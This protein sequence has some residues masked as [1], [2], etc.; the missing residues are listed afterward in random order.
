MF[1]QPITHNL[2]IIFMNKLLYIVILC[3]CA[4]S[5]KAQLS[6]KVPSETPRLV[7]G[8]VIDHFKSD[9]IHRYSQLLS[10]G[11][12]KRL[13]SAGTYCK[14][15]RYPYEYSQSGI[16]HASIYTGTNPSFHGVI[17]QTWYNRLLNKEES[18]V[19]DAN[20][21]LLIDRTG[22][23][24]KSAKN[25]LASTLGDQ[26]KL[27]SIYSKVL[28]V[29]I[30]DKAAIF[31]A[32]HAADAAYWYD[33]LSGQFI[34]STYYLDNLPNWV[35]QFNDKKFTDF[36]L[37]RS[38]TPYD[39]GVKNNISDRLKAKLNLNT[40]FSYDLRKM[41]KTQG[42]KSLTGTP[43]AN[44]LVKDF[45]ISCIVNQNMGKDD[46]VDLLSINFSFLN[47]KHKQYS[48]F[49][50]EMLDTF[51][52]LDKDIE[53][54]LKFLDKQLGMENVLVFLT[55]AQ[56]ASYTKENMNK[57]NMPTGYFSM[58]NC[59]ALLKSYLNITYGSGNWIQTYDSQQIY[60]N[61]KLIEDSKY[62]IKEIQDKVSSF[63]IQFSGVAKTITAHTLANSNFTH[64]VLKRVQASFNQ[65]RSGDIFICLESGWRHALK[66]Q[67]DR[68]TQYSYTTQVPL[69]WYGW[70]IQRS[71]ISR[72]ISIED[73]VPSI[74]NFLNLPVSPA[75]EGFT[76]PEL[77]K[78]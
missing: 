27:S 3:F 76:I 21:K 10:E 22:E 49:S 69:L 39:G 74:S 71:I 66:D 9:Y 57:N 77:T 16:D 20:V 5:V 13:I 58:Y 19:K 23:I 40:D 51:I 60:L 18:C 43:F 73:I 44:M 7:V 34:S 24:G 25:L 38:W 67:R 48:P 50:P 8:I 45:A 12:F 65:K 61:H 30:E 36:Y 72:K 32:G 11:G 59:V 78:F 17:S 75:C 29:A 70:K 56:A 63:I 6:P 28:G 33:T 42:Y 26:I 14:D 62:T 4:L 47:D 15:T 41:K 55:T 1:I 46:D 2:E 68:T 64:G 52:R 53:H 37:N 31:S 35:N 54:L